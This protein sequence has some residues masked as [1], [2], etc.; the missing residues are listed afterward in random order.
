MGWGWGGGE[1]GEGENRPM[2]GVAANSFLM[3]YHEIKHSVIIQK[4]RSEG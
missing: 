3:H 4:Y 2:S 1:G